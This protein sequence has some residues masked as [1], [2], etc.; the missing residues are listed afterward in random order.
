M[1]FSEGEKP[2]AE[3]AAKPSV[4]NWNWKI[5][6][7]PD[8][9]FRYQPAVLIALFFCAGIILDKYSGT[10]QWRFWL[11]TG[12]IS[13]LFWFLVC[14]IIPSSKRMFWGMSLVGIALTA[15]G[16]LWHNIYWNIYS[17][18]DLYAYCQTQAGVSGVMRGIILDAPRR[19]ESP[20]SLSPL[21]EY[22][23]TVF[24]LQANSIR[25]GRCWTP[26]S[27]CARV[28][29]SGH[30]TGFHAG[31]EIEFSGSGRV[32]SPAE[33]PGDFDYQEFLRSKRI[34]TVINVQNPDAVSLFSEGDRY[35]FIRWLGQCQDSAQKG[36]EKRISTQRQARLAA[37]FLLGN[38]ND[39]P[40]EMIKRFQETGTIHILVVSGMHVMMLA[41][42][43]HAI[44]RWF[45]IP[46][47]AR[48]ILVSA[49][50]MFYVGITGMQPPAVRAGILCLVGTMAALAN[51]RVLSFNALAV[52]GIIVLAL[53]PTALFQAGTQLSFLTVGTIIAFSPFVEKA[54]ER[55]VPVTQIRTLDSGIV[56]QRTFVQF[57]LQNT[58]G[59]LIMGVIILMV[60][61]PLVATRFHVLSLFSILL[62]I[63]LWIPIFLAS[64]SGMLAMLFGAIEDLPLCSFA[65]NLCAFV[66]QY[67]LWIL[68]YAVQTV[69]SWRWSRFWVTGLS[70]P[71]LAAF[72][73]ILTV[74]LFSPYWRKNRAKTASVMACWLAV[75]AFIPLYRGLTRPEQMEVEFINVGHGM[76]TLVRLPDG[77]NLLYDA[78]RM[79]NPEQGAQSVSNLLWNAGITKIHGVII[80]HADADHYNMLP[81]LAQRF[82]IDTVYLSPQ[83]FSETDNQTLQRFKRYL[84]DA[85]VKTI[86]LIRG[87]MLGDG[88][89]Y[90][91]EIL[92]PGE[93]GVLDLVSPEN[94]NS[95]VLAL[96]FANRN[97]LLTGDLVGN[98]V[99][100]IMQEDSP[101]YDVLQAPHHGSYLSLTPEFI[102][103]T[104]AQYAVFPESKAYPQQKGRALFEKENVPV[105][106]TGEDGSVQ[107][108]ISS[109]GNLVVNKK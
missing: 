5:P 63:V 17:S 98:G 11:N 93:K 2:S 101:G 20:P 108:V 6:E 1:S 44:L 68:E 22:D 9:A 46:R 12:V 33:T 75:I 67:A 50:V 60:I 18:C 61:A 34:L 79:N 57:I 92:H 53:N 89:K 43:L 103:W 87:D 58:M 59:L 65:A 78:G 23:R 85:Q 28:S 3:A 109:Q 16:G 72:Y 36:L 30:L 84:E 99:R 88:I 35:S 40:E 31:D 52:S 13:I 104:K 4:H 14:L 71:L 25:N 37:A 66:C 38:R 24:T 80:S 97:V 74:W 21:P 94:A 69:H 54:V 102:R 70:E 27:G 62:N 91:A 82:A 77:K 55:I 10:I 73:V 90:Q 64:L 51:Q 47:A 86:S 32:P 42:L 76:C 95:V 39:L 15:L 48:L 96:S 107:F 8:P 7:P 29:V 83:T 45:P 26:I 49:V 100:A 41:M 56:K 105:I 81:T 19:I 106:H